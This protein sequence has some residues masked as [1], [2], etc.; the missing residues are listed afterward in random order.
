MS[1]RRLNMAGGLIALVLVAAC[2]QDVVVGQEADSSP[3]DTIV[4]GSSDQM[5][6]PS[7]FS[8]S[9]V[10]DSSTVTTLPGLADPSSPGASTESNEARTED[11]GESDV[12]GEVVPEDTVNSVAGEVPGSLFDPVLIDAAG[13][14]GRSDLEVTRAEFVEWPD[15]SLGCPKPGVV[16]TMA[17][18]PGY[19]I[20]I[21]A[22]DVTL[23]YRMNAAGLFSLCESGDS[24]SMITPR[25]PLLPVDDSRVPPGSG[26]GEDGA[27]SGT[28]SSSGV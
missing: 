25:E 4:A 23:D 21:R 8:P 1:M 3:G 10:D 9:A 11:R 17:I 14:L 2:S 5:S 18:T 19:W 16:Y 12:P 24:T 26:D 6:D 28:G 7:E 27:G 20:E 13:R 22:N 15:G